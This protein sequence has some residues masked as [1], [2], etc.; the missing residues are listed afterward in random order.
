MIGCVIHSTTTEE[1][2]I[3]VELS[4]IKNKAVQIFLSDPTKI[5]VKKNIRPGEI[6]KIREIIKKNNI[7]VIIHTNFI[8]NLTS[9][10]NNKCVASLINELKICGMIGGYGVVIHCGNKNKSIKNEEDGL[11]KTVKLIERIIQINIENTK[12]YNRKFT[13]YVLVENN[14]GIKN[15]YGNNIQ[16]LMKIQ[17]TIN[18]KY[19]KNFGFCIDTAHLWGA[20][21][22]MRTINKTKKII[23]DMSK[24]RIK[25]FH[26]NNTITPF[27]TVGD[28]HASIFT[29]Q[30]PHKSLQ[31]FIP[32]AA[33]LNIPMILE[34]KECPEKDINMINEIYNKYNK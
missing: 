16:Y 4:K 10:N 29:G 5:S 18:P 17:K 7:I 9:G 27:G 15:T 11:E 8:C 31:L 2:S 3:S 28:Q 26:I 23:K 32:F 30:I 33:K 22:D 34:L 12:A 21:Y 20:G 1:N 14:S 13:P 19:N 6:S 25:L 24:L